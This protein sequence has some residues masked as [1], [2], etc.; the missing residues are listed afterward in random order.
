MIL[1]RQPK[2]FWASVFPSGSVCRLVA[3]P[4]VNSVRRYKFVLKK[5]DEGTIC[6][7]YPGRKLLANATKI[8]FEVYKFT[9]WIWCQISSI[10]DWQNS[11][12]QLSFTHLW[13]LSFPCGSD[14][15]ESICL[16]CGRQVRSLGGKI[17]WR[18]ACNPLQYSC[19]ENPMDRGAWRAT[20]HG[21]AEGRTRLST[22]VMPEE[23][24]FH[25]LNGFRGL[26]C[27]S[28]GD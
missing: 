17:R 22:Q 23:A 5:P 21:I 3:Q 9:D 16:Q 15:K 20:V 6:F 12:L 10:L 26:V 18:R 19:L 14:G 28:R 11:A 24:A 13:C 4:S 27:F 25:N 7:V 2:A 1:T 8:Y